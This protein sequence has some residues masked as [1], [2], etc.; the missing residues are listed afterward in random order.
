MILASVIVFAVAHERSAKTYTATASVAFQSDTLT[1][2]A[3]NIATVTS[4]EPQREADTEVLIAHSA[5]VAHSVR[6][7]LKLSNH[8]TNCW[9]R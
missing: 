5:E 3:L 1:D 7:Q 2:A 8:L 9:P 4:S 6:E